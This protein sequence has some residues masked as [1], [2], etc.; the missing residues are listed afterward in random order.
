MLRKRW[1]GVMVVA[2]VLEAMLW[3]SANGWAQETGDAPTKLQAMEKI[4]DPDW[5]VV[6]VRAADP[7]GLNSG[8]HLEG[9]DIDIERKTVENMLQWGYGV[10][11][12]QIANAPEWVREEVWDAKGYANMLGQPSVKQFQGLTRKLLAERFGLVTHTEQREMAVYVLTVAKGGPKLAVSKSD[13]NGQQNGND[14]PNG[15]E[16]TM[17]MEN[18]P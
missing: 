16:V 5:D 11:K 6:S 13:P 14:G 2:A 4:D 7:D 1:L 18:C 10:H 8:Y 12:T 3:V 9:R 17:Q 15:G